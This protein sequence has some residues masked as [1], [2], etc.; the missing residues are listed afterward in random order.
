VTSPL[1]LGD[2]SLGATA[3]E[4]AVGH[5]LITSIPGSDFTPESGLDM[6]AVTPGL[7][8]RRSGELAWRFGLCRA[9]GK[10]ASGV[11]PPLNPQE[12]LCSGAVRAFG[13]AQVWKGMAES[14]GSCS[15]IVGPGE[16]H[17]PTVSD[18]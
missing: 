17:G 12:R 16:D 3:I 6:Q 8:A 9:S 2:A 18:Q 14:T 7:P 11:P 1:L 13:S 10:P 15:W 5:P 4:P